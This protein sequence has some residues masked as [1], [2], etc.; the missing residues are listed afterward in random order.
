MSKKKKL[1]I[2][3]AIAIISFTVITCVSMKRY[4]LYQIREEKLLELQNHKGNYDENTIILSNTSLKRAEELALKLN[5]SLRITSNGEYAELKLPKDVNTESVFSNKD[6]LT[7]LSELSI[8]YK[9]SLSEISDAETSEESNKVAFSPSSPKYEVND[10][11]YNYQ[12]YLDYLNLQD[13]WTKTKG[14]TS[15][16]KITVAIIDTGIDTDHPEFYD[17]N[18]NFIVSEY[19]YNASKGQVVNTTLTSEGDYD[20]SIIEDQQHEIEGSYHGT[21]VAGVIAAQ[22]NNGI[23]IAGIAP[24]VE[25]LVIKCELDENGKL[26]TSD[27]IFGLYYAIERD[28]DVVNMSFGSDNYNLAWEG[29]LKLAYDSDIICVASAG[30]ENSSSPVYPAALDYVISV[31]SLAANSWEKADYSNYGDW[32][33]IFAPEVNWSTTNDGYGYFSG[34]SSSAPVV[35]SAIALYKSVNKYIEFD[36]LFEVLIASTKDIGDLGPDFYYGWGALDINALIFE[37]KGTVTFDYLTDEMNS[38][39]QVFVRNHT[40]QNI[41]EPERLYVVFDGW[42]YDIHCENEVNYYEDIWN[43][44]ITLYAKWVNEDEGIPYTYTELADGTLKLTSYIGKRRYITIP[45]EIDGKKV[46]TIGKECFAYN[47][48]LRTINLPEELKY[49]EESAFENCSYLLN[50]TIPKSVISIG[51]SAFLNCSRLSTVGMYGD[52]DL[53]I[54]EDYAFRNCGR[55]VRIDLP[56]NL[57]TL[58][59]S[60]FYGCNQLKQIF[61]SNENKYFNILNNILYSEDY[62]TLIYSP[63]GNSEEIVIDDRVNIIGVAAFAYYKHNTI[64][65]HNGIKEINDYA[66]TNSNL[67]KIE[68][69]T[70]VETI[71]SYV[72][73]Q[74]MKLKEVSFKENNNLVQLGSH[75][76]RACYALETVNNFEKCNIKTISELLFYGCYNLK[77]IVIPSNV[78]NI[79]SNAFYSCSNLTNIKIP[80]N[81]TKIE[82]SSFACSGLESIEF[83][84][85][86]KLD[87]I[88]GNLFYGCLNLS[89]IDIPKSVIEIG[90]DAFK[91]SGLT[92][93]CVG[94]NIKKIGKGAFSN[95]SKLV[96]LE[97][98]G[99]N[100]NYYSL[101]NAIYYLENGETILHTFA[102]GITG[103]FTIPTDVSVIDDY[104][105]FGSL[106][107]NVNLN[108]GLI[109][110][111]DYAFY[112]CANL[113]DISFPSTLTCLN[114]YSFAS[115]SSLEKILITKNI[116]R[117]LGC[118]F[119]ECWNLKSIEFEEESKLTRF[120]FLA[121][122]STGIEKITIPSSIVSIAQGA[123]YGT[124]NLSEVIFEEGSDIENI[125]GYIFDGAYNLTTINFPENNNIKHIQARAFFGMSKLQYINWESLNQLQE[126]DNYAFWGCSSLDNVVLP[127]TLTYIGR[128]AFADCG[129]IERIDIPVNVEYIGRYAFN[130]LRNLDV[131]FKSSVLPAYLQE[132]WDYS[133]KGY[134]V[135][136]A[137]VIEN[138]EYIYA[139]LFDNTVQISKYLGNDE[140]LIINKIDGYNV[141][142]IG[143][144][145]F[146]NNGNIKNISLPNTIVAIYDYAFANTSNLEIINIPDSVSLIQDYA[147]YNSGIKSINLTSKLT[148]IGNY[149]FANTVNLES[150]IIPSSIEKIGDYAFYNSNINSLIIEENSELHTIGKYAFSESNLSAIIFPDSLTLIDSYA[151]SNTLN[152]QKLSF[153]NGELRVNSNAF[154]N[155]GISGELFIPENLYYIGEFCF[156]LCKNITSFKVSENNKYY[157]SNEGMLC[158]KEQTKLISCPGGMTGT[159][160]FDDS[161]LSISLGAFEGSSLEEIIIN[162]NSRLI[163]IGYR[164]FTNMKNLKRITIPDS[165]L[166]IDYY[167]FAYCENLEEVVISENSLMSGIYEGAFYNCSSLKNIYIP[168]GVQEISDYAFYGCSSLKNI[169][170]AENSELKGIY[171]YAFSYSGIE[172][173]DF[174]KSLIEIGEYAFAN[175]PNIN[176]TELV[177]PEN[178]EE[179]GYGAFIGFDKLEK[180][181]FS[182][183]DYSIYYYFG[184]LYHNEN[185]LPKNLKEISII[186]GTSV[187]NNAF[188]N[189]SNL[190]KIY[191]NDDITHI[192]ESA[193]SCCFLLTEINIPKNLISIGDYAFWFTTIKEFYLGDKIEVIGDSAFTTFG[194]SVCYFKGDLE[195]IVVGRNAFT[196]SVIY[197]NTKEIKTNDQYKYLVRN[198]DKIIILEYFGLEEKLNVDYIDNME[199]VEIGMDAFRNTN[200]TEIILSNNITKIG[201]AAFARCYNL[202]SIVIP[203]SITNIGASAFDNCINLENVILPNSISAIEEFTFNYCESLRYIYIP[204]N[205][206]YIGSYAFFSNTTVL[207]ESST[208]G[209]ENDW[210]IVF[211]TG[212]EIS[213]FTNVSE[214]L[215]N[216]NFKYIVVQEKLVYILEYIGQEEKLSIQ[217]IDGYDII[218]G[219]SAFRKSEV[220]KE[221]EITN[222]VKEICSFAFSECYNLEKITINSSIEKMGNSIFSDCHNLREVIITGHLETLPKTIFSECINLR[223]VVIPNGVKYIDDYAFSGCIALENIELPQTLEKIGGYAFTNTGILKLEIP[224]SVKNFDFN[225]VANATYLKTIIFSDYIDSIVNTSWEIV[226]SSIIFIFSG[227]KIPDNI[228]SE[229]LEN[230]TWY[231]GIK[232]YIENEKGLYLV[233]TSNRAYLMENYDNSEEITIDLINEYEI[234]GISPKAFDN[235]YTAKKIIFG[236]KIKEVGSCAFENCSLL[237]EVQLSEDLKIIG[238]KAFIGC[239]NLNF[240]V[241]PCGIEKIGKE[242]F[243]QY[244]EIVICF[245]GSELPKNRD[246]NWNN[247][248]EYVLNISKKIQ[249]DNYQL[250]LRNDNKVHIIKYI[251]DEKEIVIDKVGEYEVLSIFSGAFSNCDTLEKVEIKSHIDVIKSNLFKNCSNLLEVIIPES[252]TKIEK[253]AFE[254]CIN[255]EKIRVPSHLNSIGHYAFANCKNLK[256]II[257]PL[258]TY[259]IGDSAFS[260]CSNLEYIEINGYV[261]IGMLSFISVDGEIKFSKYSNS[262]EIWSTIWCAGFNGNVIYEC[263]DEELLNEYSDFSFEITENGATLIAYYGKDSFV[264]VP[265]Y[266]Y[267]IPVSEINCSLDGIIRI[268]ESVK[269]IDVNTVSNSLLLFE[270]KIINNEMMELLERCNQSNYYFGFEE[271][272]INSDYEYAVVEKGAVIIKYLGTEEKIIIDYIDG[273]PVIAIGC[274][275]FSYNDN[276]KYLEIINNVEII[277]SSSFNDCANLKV[278]KIISNLK[279]IGQYAF[280]GCSKLKSVFLPKTISKIGINVFNSWR[281]TYILFGATDLPK[282][283]SDGWSGVNNEYAFDVSHN[284]VYSNLIYYVTNNG[285]LE[286]LGIFDESL[287]FLYVPKEID[288]NEVK[289][290]SVLYDLN[291]MYNL[292]TV[293][294]DVAELPYPFYWSDNIKNIVLG[295]DYPNY[296]ASIFNDNVNVFL[297]INKEDLELK[298]IYI[299]GNNVEVYYLN[300][301]NDIVYY[302]VNDDI[303]LYDVYIA[304]ETIRLPANSLLEVKDNNCVYE[305]L[306]WDY[307]NDGVVDNIPSTINRNYEFKSIY[308]ITCKHLNLELVVDKESTCF[309]KGEGYYKC[310]NCDS[311]KSEMIEIPL[312][313]HELISYNRKEPTCIEEGHEAYEACNNCNYTTYKELSSLGHSYK[314]EIILPTCTEQ[315]YTTYTCHCGDSYVS[316]YVDALGHNHEAIITSPTCTEQ[317]YTT[318]I[319]HC[320]DS[321]ISDYVD[322]LGHIEV[323]DKAVEPTCTQTGLTEGKHCSVCNEV[324][325]KQEVVEALGHDYESVVTAPTCEMKGYTTYTCHC[326][327]SY[328]SDY[329][330][331]LGHTEVIDKAVEPTCTETGLTEG[332]HC[333][334][335]N[336]VLVKQ[337][338]VEALGHKYEEVVTKPT[339]TEKGYTTYT[340][341]CE[342][343][344]VSDY[345]A[346][347]GHTEVT[348]KAVEP[349]CTQTGLTEGKH[350]SVCKEVLVKQ[351][352]IDALGHDYETIVTKPTCIEKG[353]TTYTCHCK[354]SYVS[355]YVDALGHTE[356][357]DKAVEPTCTQTGLTEGKHCSVCKKVLV[358]QEVIDA[359]DHDYEAV[360]TAPTCETKGYTTHTCHCGD[361]YISD[362]VD[363]LGHTEVIDKAVDPTCT[364]TGLTEGKHCSVCNEVLVKQE[365]VEALGHKYKVIITVPTC[366]TKGYTTYICHCKYSYVSDYVDALGHT[367]VI[368]KAVKPTCTETG[369]TEGKHCSVCK[370][371]LVKQEVVD[372]LG[373]SYSEWKE[374]LKPTCTKEGKEQR[375]CNNC[376]H[377]EE[378][379]ISKIAHNYKD[380]IVEPTCTEQGYTLHRCDQCNDEYKDSYTDKVEH[381]LIE[382]AN[383]DKECTMCDYVE[384][385]QVTT[386]SCLSKSSMLYIWNIFV[387]GIV[388]FILKKKNH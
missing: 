70:S 350:C 122:A 170:F 304:N 132:N 310:L 111:R 359:L 243:D 212:E 90:S 127:D 51:S 193:F 377:F 371:V 282:N 272:K 98:D 172:S 335:C 378:K 301:W 93:F 341:H 297:D 234:V 157:S 245:E 385:K 316:D 37:E 67:V 8:N 333:S 265:N 121:F 59:G 224:E 149:S 2:V 113:V 176:I 222:D 183:M 200:I 367:K 259:Y 374:I 124:S 12:G 78:I 47:T 188:I 225:S 74:S 116:E 21:K 355:D 19:S 143:G 71:G 43:E 133:I 326:G 81:V 323:I 123:F 275:A 103:D 104:A 387:G 252:V 25:L 198:D 60:A 250:L 239:R 15:G 131:Y 94:P 270:S 254:N 205:V 20:W 64:L 173:I 253:S 247:E 213:Y 167:A 110:I 219:T 332:K 266:Y 216:T 99:D 109:E 23:G 189:C 6:N 364:E 352:V 226:D 137:D 89:N 36:Q 362:Y 285:Q 288:G 31:G 291:E 28:A 195:N 68:I 349:T 196:N 366:E 236:D 380:T 84:E 107:T 289:N 148:K 255:L 305:F 126:I 171:Q 42:Y 120:E 280:S 322:A 125:T 169:K 14:S 88:S 153:G 238:D 134:Y 344:Y 251:G 242:V 130:R 315:G 101:D 1:F 221:L 13:V 175:M 35:S 55:L 119:F 311:Y 319:C 30:N 18:N 233:D 383:G 165:V 66:F 295:A 248:N 241:I 298:E 358:K 382:N 24:D 218:I 329:V 61:I 227:E 379:S 209:F 271:I 150:I 80:V 26:N 376:D 229:L 63:A 108:E 163:T 244:A 161:T 5:A 223:N 210:N 192:G 320:G 117:I 177:I 334:V 186:K 92:T 246:I 274:K 86:S 75:C 306:G 353:Y 373:H 152:L 48:R 228:D 105:F 69:P 351:E 286:I 357:I 277:G 146:E 206:T 283:A 308:K 141:T 232:E 361:S 338:V 184:S 115:C 162:E 324:L 293:K 299:Y 340:C 118:A 65:L 386:K 57:K 317:G 3:I 50:I 263:E 217:K 303:I 32:V 249:I 83:D 388:V 4:K 342:D 260:H 144:H 240:I 27:I 168:R 215:E 87:I 331:A 62:T 34:T 147:F 151:F 114:S 307:T 38:T 140:N 203:N 135:G 208:S 267:G 258:T 85:N 187:P 138:S 384:K 312:K 202:T 292:K 214:M 76:F 369:L 179:I 160:T 178:V 155:S 296:S 136:V 281:G 381:T 268:P 52:S 79:E 328:I 284:G 72:F 145:A 201:E 10:P 158:N 46:S 166:S 180:I 231:T 102:S 106:I 49:I 29:A 95:C 164:A 204:S 348:D 197:C 309:E 191:L 40:L 7:L 159:Y 262:S 302:D 73:Y 91:N 235:N 207:L 363:A 346:A 290:V 96:G 9:T 156:S 375:N 368:D 58:N 220:L 261:Y 339:C 321:Y 314:K 33:D 129:N 269:K 174:P 142:A 154:N 181:S 278:V 77:D 343:S 97:V 264:N 11:D 279:V 16:E 100:A 365:V 276:I 294:I 325:I 237:E 347:L 44:D 372:A 287:E 318:Y 370:K 360:V 300:E 128:Y 45:S 273:L 22:M 17:S 139:L 256:S 356:V 194:S 41:P 39:N 82:N 112:N 230:R 53:E 345:V 337:E 354:D 327:D 56:D 199:V 330:D 336:E 313:E 190:E 211:K 54:I 257:I 185:V 182:K